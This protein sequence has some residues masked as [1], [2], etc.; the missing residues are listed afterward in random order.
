MIELPVQVCFALLTLVKPNV[1]QSDRFL[2]LSDVLVHLRDSDLHAL[3]HSIP[4]NLHGFQM[5]SSAFVLLLQVTD[6]LASHDHGLLQLP[7][8]RLNHLDFI[9]CSTKFAALMFVQV[10]EILN[11][12][13]QLVF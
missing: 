2:Q 13:L 5:V 1:L 11:F 8:V 3:L 6:L 9:G 4:L 12:R 7:L 10:P